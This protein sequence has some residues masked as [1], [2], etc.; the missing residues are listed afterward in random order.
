[1]VSTTMENG[2]VG[3]ALQGISDSI[4]L[5]DRQLFQLM[6]FRRLLIL[7][8]AEDIPGKVISVTDD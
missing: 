8:N 5:S 4:L 7:S 2:C 1:M 6:P 3:S